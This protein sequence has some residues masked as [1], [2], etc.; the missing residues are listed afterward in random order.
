MSDTKINYVIFGLI[1][2]FINWFV[3]WKI[4]PRMLRDVS[5]RDISTS[6][7]GY[8]IAFPVCVAPTAMHKMAHHEGE[9]AT[10]KGRFLIRSVK[11]I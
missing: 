6:V 10:A 4:R 1:F 9:V 5:N 2:S 8:N 7:L 11:L 3:S